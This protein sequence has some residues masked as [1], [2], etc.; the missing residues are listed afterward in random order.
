[1]LA[2]AH[3]RF[4]ALLLS[5]SAVLAN[6][7]PN[8]P[9][10]QQKTTNVQVSS[11]TLQAACRDLCVFLIQIACDN[12]RQTGEGEMRLCYDASGSA[13]W[14]RGNTSLVFDCTIF[15][16]C[17]VGWIWSGGRLRRL[18]LIWT[19]IT[20]KEVQSLWHTERMNVIHPKD[21]LYFLRTLRQVV[22]LIMLVVDSTVQ[23]IAPESLT[24]IEI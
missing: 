20:I 14:S 15:R 9:Q 5:H 19:P 24:H 11:V 4:C 23:A 8:C 7:Q 2:C 21:V 18:L 3:Q 22:F 1:M 10:R 12:L 17:V 13:L 6:L 16:Y